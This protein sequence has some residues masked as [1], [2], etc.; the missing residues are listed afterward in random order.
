[1]SIRR[2]EWSRL[3]GD[4]VLNHVACARDEGVD[5]Y[6]F[7]IRVPGR[8]DLRALTAHIDINGT[9]ELALMLPRGM[10]MDQLGPL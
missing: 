5:G 6:P 7:A 4:G 3:L 8:L 2:C 9:G 10:L 1:M